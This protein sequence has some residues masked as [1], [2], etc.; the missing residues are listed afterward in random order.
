[1]SLVFIELESDM[2][3]GSDSLVACSSL[4]ESDWASSSSFGTSSASLDS[5][6]FSFSEATDDACSDASVSDD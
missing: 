2:V 3:S 1:M 6:S 4:S 5:D